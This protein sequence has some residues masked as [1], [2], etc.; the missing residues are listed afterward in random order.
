TGQ[1]QPL[2]LNDPTPCPDPVYGQDLLNTLVAAF[3][4][5]LALPLHAAQAL[6]LWVPHA[7]A[8]D[9]ATTNPRLAITL[10]QKRCGKTTLVAVL[11]KLVPRPLKAANISPAAVFRVIE[12]CEPTLL[13]D[14]ADTFVADNHELRGVL[15]N[16]HTRATAFVI[17]SVGDD[18]EP[19]CFATWCPMAIAAIGRVDGSLD[20]H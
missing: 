9:V 17:R 14:E 8:L 1:G 10:P 13:L 16:G 19:R 20:R 6:A 7:Y 3:N 15:N 18:H 11:D 2:D 12:A 4:R 5:Y